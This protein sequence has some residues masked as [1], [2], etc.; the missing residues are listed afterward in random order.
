MPEHAVS[1]DFGRGVESGS[2]HVAQGAGLLCQQPNHRTDVKRAPR[3]R[4]ERVQGALQDRTAR[5][6]ARER[7]VCG[8]SG[9]RR[10]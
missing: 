9:P 4:T 7:R 1:G 3:G 10:W 2:Q 8:R 6:S 5:D